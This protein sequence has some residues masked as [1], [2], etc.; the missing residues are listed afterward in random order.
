MLG[1]IQG[2]DIVIYDCMYTDDEYAKSYVGWGHSTW[3]EAVRLCKPAGVKKLVVF[4]HDPDH[5]DD[6]MDAIGRDVAAAMPGAVVAREGME[7]KL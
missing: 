1:L 2:A 6:R 5:D 7:L 4:H 3:Q